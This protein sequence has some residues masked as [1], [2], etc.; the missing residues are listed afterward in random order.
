MGMILTKSVFIHIPRTGGTWV[1]CILKNAGLRNGETGRGEDYG[2][3]TIHHSIGEAADWI[4]EGYKTFSFIRHPVTYLKSRWARKSWPPMQEILG[5]EAMN[6]LITF[7]QF[8]E[9]YLLYCP[10]SITEL[11][12]KMTGWRMDGT[13]DDIHVDFI[14]KLENQPFDLINILDKCREDV[15]ISLIHNEPP[16]HMSNYHNTDLS[17]CKDTILNILKAEEPICKTFQYGGMPYG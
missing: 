11:Y 15:P 14:G 3:K 6:E 10:G 1:R 12:K 7:Q 5:Q 8:A 16:C 9:Y 13:K 17:L 4:P 2:V